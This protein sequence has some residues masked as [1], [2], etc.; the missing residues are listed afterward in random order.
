MG[1]S[2]VHA[3]HLFNNKITITGWFKSNDGKVFP[4][5]SSRRFLGSDR[6]FLHVFYE[7]ALAKTWPTC[8]FFFF[9]WFSPAKIFWEIWASPPNICRHP[10][11]PPP[12]EVRPQDGQIEHVCAQIF[13]V[14]LWKTA[15]TFG[16]LCG[17]HV[18]F[19]SLSL[20]IS[21]IARRRAQSTC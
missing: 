21:W 10:P 1:Q 5:Q 7:W 17:K 16:L 9:G 3:F 14:Y 8:F 4:G 2:V 6:I 18:K 19:A 15:W 11:P 20:I 13:R 12:P